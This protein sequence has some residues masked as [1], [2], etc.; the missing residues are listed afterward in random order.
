MQKKLFSRLQNLNFRSKLVISFLII[1]IIPILILVFLSFYYFTNIMKKN[2]DFLIKEKLIQSQKN[3][4]M[5]MTSYDDLLFQIFTDDEIIELVKKFNDNPENQYYYFNV[6][7]SKLNTLAYTK[8]GIRSI[9]IF[10]ANGKTVCYDKAAG[11]KIYHLW[12]KFKDVRITD[13]YQKTSQVSTAL[14]F[15]TDYFEGYNNNYVFHMTRK[16]FDINNLDTRCIGVIVL[17]IN[18]YMIFNSCNTE[19]DILEKNNITFVLDKNGRI[20]SFPEKSLIGKKIDNVDKA[21]NAKDRDKMI[22]AFMKRTLFQDKNS[23]L[24]NEISDVKSQWTVANVANID[25]LFSRM[26]WMQRIIIMLGLLIVCVSIFLI[27]SVSE[28]LSRSIRKIVDAMKIVQTGNLDVEIKSESN[29]EISLISNN[30]NQMICDIKKLLNDVYV[31]T[32]KQKEAEISALESQINPHFLYNTIDSINWVAIEKDE[33]EISE[34]LCC[35][36]TILR[37]SIN[38]SNKIV[39]LAEEIEW[40]EQYIFLQQKRFNNS[41]DVFFDIKSDILDCKIHKL[42]FQP[43]IENSIIHGFKK[44]K[45][46]GILLIS[47]EKVSDDIFEIVIKDNGSGINREKLDFIR[48]DIQEHIKTGGSGI[49]M[50]NAFKR[51]KSYYGEKVSWIIESNDSEGTIIKICLPVIYYITEDGAG[52]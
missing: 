15:P 3:I 37:Y 39:G 27:F 36:A 30:F 22:A 2:T 42:L 17:S 8:E 24:I 49:G 44:V 16:M 38:E 21:G 41:F 45:S 47:G 35:L 11:T 34:M 23:I 40:M 46:G 1:C 18:E 31:A 25:V 10:C 29:D 50:K 48:N 19:S 28:S 7:T 20:I 33:H 32:Q 6:L 43:F 12:S 14:L 4:N 26:F 51:M 9:A 5:M 52:Q 13:I